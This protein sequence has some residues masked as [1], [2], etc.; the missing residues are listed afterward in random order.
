[1]T[2]PHAPDDALATAA[3]DAL[4]AR[5]RTAHHLGIRLDAIAPGYAR[6]SLTVQEWMLQGHDMCHGGIMF[7]LADTAMAFASNS[8]GTSHVALNANIDFLRPAFAGETLVAEARE[9]NRT[10]RTG[11]YDVSIVNAAGETVCHFRGR[12]YGTGA[13]VIR[14]ETT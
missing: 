9:G 3:G 12:T 2:D 13:P 8:R 5:D 6:M 7:A 1:M 4:Y 11:M 14:D 10:R